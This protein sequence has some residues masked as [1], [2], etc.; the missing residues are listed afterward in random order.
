MIARIVRSSV[1][2]RVLVVSLAALLIAA[3][4]GF[5]RQ[6]PVDV[7]PEFTPPTVE[8][9][10][11]ALGL[12]AVEV[13]QLITVP[14][15]QDLLNGLP[16]LD[17]IRSESVPG[18]SSVE[19]IFEPGTDLMRA[20]QV[21]QERLTQSH[22]LPNVS[23]TPQ[24][25][26]SVSSTNRVMMVGLS[27]KTLS[28]IDVSVLARWSIRP[29]LMGIPGVAGVSVWGQRERQLQVQV[30]PKRLRAKGVS[31]LQVVKTTGNALWVSPLSFLEAST[32]G[33]GGFIDTPNQRLSIQHI[34]PIKTAHDL[35]RVSLEDARPGM[36][37]GD[38]ATVVQDHQPLIGDAILSSGP[39]LMLV[40]QKFPGANTLDVTR[41]VEDALR[42]M[43]SGLT[44]VDIDPSI[45]R[46]ATYIEQSMSNLG[47]ALAIA[48]GLLLL[49][50]LVL[51]ASWRSAFIAITTI[52]GSVAA[53]FAVLRLRGMSLNAMVLVG[54][55]IAL[56]AIIDDCILDV[57][58][59][60]ARVRDPEGRGPSAVV[61]AIFA[62]STEM[63][64]SI[65]YAV[66]IIALATVPV[67]FLKG[68]VRVLFSPIALSYVFAIL[69]SM[70]VVLAVT[71]AMCFVLF[72]SA[73]HPV[74]SS[75]IVRGLARR[76]RGGVARAMRRP[77]TMVAALC[78]LTIA[79]AATLP[80]LRRSVVPQFKDPN[81]LVHWEAA[82][83]TSLTEMNRITSLVGDELR[84]IPGVIRVGAHVGR[85]VLSDQVV[86]PNSGELW[87]SLDPKAS[88]DSTA[89]AVEAV[90]GAY[91]GID[92]DVVTYPSERI[93]DIVSQGGEDFVV[94]VYGQNL[95]VLH[96]KAEEVRRTL[97]SIEGVVHEHVEAQLNEPTLEV[98][99]DLE[100][101]QR[102]GIKPGDVRRGAATLLSGLE[103]GSL[104]EEQ[105]VFE[106][107][108]WSTPDTR[109]NLTTIRDLVIDRP[110]GGYVRLGDVANVRVR[111]NP[112][113]VRHDDVSR[114]VE[115][116]ADIRGRDVGAVLRDVQRRIRGIN[117]PLEYHA[118]IASPYIDRHAAA[119]RFVTLAL[120]ALAGMFLLFQAAFRSWRLATLALLTLPVTVV[121]GLVATLVS[122]RTMSLGASG[123]VLAL[124]AMAVRNTIVSFRRLQAVEADAAMK[125][126][127][128]DVARVAERRFAHIFISSLALA[129][130][131]LPIII[132]G[133]VAGLEVL[134]PMAVVILGGLTTAVMS[135]LFIQPALY[136]RF[137][138]AT[139]RDDV[140][141]EADMSAGR[142]VLIDVSQHQDE[143]WG[144]RS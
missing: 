126:A 140:W 129:S 19:M 63:R 125:L 18:L 41:R 1:R 130:I 96:D 111:P 115:V 135:S 100:A 92:H 39:G 95:D 76:Y 103:V 53:A 136:L 73:Q 40:I 51:F 52:A 58:E 14:L 29:K 119:V 64:G 45:F 2:R 106:V 59:I 82:A 68:Q 144:V 74:R 94:R 37:L 30:D 98:E 77:R 33:T 81:L 23:K 84:A 25:L 80:F 48:L 89:S 124:F 78:I 44:G 97:S 143:P 10:T 112:N 85:A 54:L 21:V 123:G 93:N 13:E 38:V 50:L 47:R 88:Y 49:C 66:L 109:R 16:W 27:S 83:G 139:R 56:A 121:G 87:V 71:P 142:G 46:P 43:Q 20:R 91:P 99:V 90:V 34:L 133:G 31:L 11:E 117:F 65:V 107:I 75:P 24:M 104:F 4:V 28:L 35:S 61:N 70:F 57:T 9:Q 32:P 62:A 60:V 3:G 141:Q 134:Q 110:G 138:R 122:G 86:S 101:A 12:S 137:A 131:L 15:E 7:L 79:G 102:F 22:G 8:V 105:K 113:V 67:L 118:E 26:Q 69:A 42:S 17:V 72:A 55:V 36:R 5:A 132:I 6:M 128:D 108:V 116:D 114:S 120:V 127:L